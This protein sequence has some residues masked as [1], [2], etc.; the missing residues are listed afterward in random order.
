MNKSKTIAVCLATSALL[1]PVQKAF[2]AKAVHQVKE[3]KIQLVCVKEAQNYWQ[4]QP[5]NSQHSKATA[6]SFSTLA[7]PASNSTLQS[8]VFLLLLCIGSISTGLILNKQ[9]RKNRANVLRRNVEMLERAWR[10]SNYQR[11]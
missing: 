2:G 4:C 7:K 1:V 10:I 11:E 8:E 6:N 3:Q 9:H 5:K